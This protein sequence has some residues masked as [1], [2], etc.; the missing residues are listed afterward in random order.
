MLEFKK[1]KPGQVIEFGKQEAT[2]LLK[3]KNL[4][5]YEV[6][7][8]TSSSGQDFSIELEKISEKSSI[9]IDEDIN[10]FLNTKSVSEFLNTK[11]DLPLK[12]SSIEK[13]TSSLF[14]GIKADI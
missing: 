8:V 10:T 1:G 9:L 2:N 11:E 14:E 5:G 13:I 6:T 4:D 7:K 3:N 12:D